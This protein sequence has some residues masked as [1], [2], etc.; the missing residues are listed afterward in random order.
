LIKAL[1]QPFVAILFC[2]AFGLPFVFVGFQAVHI[3]GAKDQQ[4]AVTLDFN[5]R[6]YWGVW[7]VEEQ[8]ENVRHATLRT[9]FTHRSNPRRIRM[10]SGVFIETETE[11]V[12]LL[13]GS[14]NVDDDLKRDIV[15]SINDFIND[16]EQSHYTRTFRVANVFGWVGLP[17]LALGVLGIL[18]WP[19][20]IVK[21]WR[22]KR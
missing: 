4:G 7:Q 8:V 16:P 2:L 21:H 13:A 1:L 6:H 15:E 19:F 20:S 9:S 14:S 3:E 18:G 11:A 10:T 17:F 22:E 5:R 12:R